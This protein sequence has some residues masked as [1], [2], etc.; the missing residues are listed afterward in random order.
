MTASRAPVDYIEVTRDA[1]AALGYSAYR[2]VRNEDA[3]PWASLRRPLAESVAYYFDHCRATAQLE[4]LTRPG[5]LFSFRHEDMVRAPAATLSALCAFL[6]LEAY[7]GYLEDCAR[8][9]FPAPTCTRR[10][11]DWP[12]ALVRE[13]ERRAGALPF[14]DGY[15]FALDDAPAGG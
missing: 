1:Y 7:P 6:G 12:D 3:P 14:L 15:R 5:E 2:W 10:K 8:V 9:V 4:A 13:V 11:L